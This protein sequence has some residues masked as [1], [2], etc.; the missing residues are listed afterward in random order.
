MAA[1]DKEDGNECLVRFEF[2]VRMERW[3][4][5]I[6]FDE[7]SLFASKND[8]TARIHPEH[9][10]SVLDALNRHLEG[11]TDRFEAEYQIKKWD[12]RYI[13]VLTRG[14]AAR[15]ENGCAISAEAHV[16]AVLR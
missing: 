7:E 15:D 5:I 12:G 9:K 10:K 4:E 2:L 11:G 13:W 8:W 3:M 16:V 6:G 14:L 1:I